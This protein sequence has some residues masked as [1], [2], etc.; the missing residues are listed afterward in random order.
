MTKDEECFT[1]PE[2]SCVNVPKTVFE[3][4]HEEKCSDEYDQGHLL[5]RCHSLLGWFVRRLF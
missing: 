4:I 5:T 3:T 1:V 2:L